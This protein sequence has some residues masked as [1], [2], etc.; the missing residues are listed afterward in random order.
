[1]DTS[2]SVPV[3]PEIAR[4]AGQELQGFASAKFAT[5]DVRDGLRRATE[6]LAHMPPAR[7]E[8]VIVSDFQ[9][10]AIDAESLAQV[11]TAVGLRFIRAG[12]PSTPAELPA[13]TGWRGG[14]WQPGMTVRGD[15][16][17]V[18]YAARPSDTDSADRTR[19]LSFVTTRQAADDA[20][21]ASAALTGAAS[22]GT[23]AE[24]SH[25]AVVVFAGA[26][27]EV[28]EQPLSTPW[29]LAAALDLRQSALLRETGAGVT[30]AEK[31]GVLVVH[32]GVRAGAAAAPGVLR[33][34]MLALRPPA[35]ADPEFETAT[36]PDGELSA[37][38]REP[39]LAVRG[40]SLVSDGLEA[41]WLWAA[42]LV[43]LGI[44]TWIR[45]RQA[46]AAQEAHADA[47]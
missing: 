38:R 9:R 46:P 23:A 20:D 28:G 40:D 30:L 33:A 6:W 25:R 15:V 16:V 35:I 26:P 37:W 13:I 14:A 1:V 31:D 41:R 18:T 29:M 2:R 17:D 27:A 4:L 24:G 19:P 7:R 45:R 34:V 12:V 36:I 44:E 3:T 21:A 43:L 10:G 32:T 5:P 8:I 11:P 47:A 39:G 22:F 42:A